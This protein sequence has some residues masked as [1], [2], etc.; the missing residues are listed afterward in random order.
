MKALVWTGV[1]TMEVRE[2][3]RPACGPDEILIRVEAV[4]ICG[5]EIEGY[6]GHNSL[7][8]PPLVMGHE[9]CGTVVDAGEGLPVAA[10]DANGAREGRSASAYGS[11]S[12]GQK[13]VVNPLLACGECPSCRRGLPQL[14]AKRALVGVHRPGAFGELVSVP[15]SAVVPVP[16]DISPFRA[17]LSEPLACSLRATRRALERHPFAGVLVFGAGGIGLLCAMTAKLLGASRVMIA[18]TNAK[19]L[20]MAASLD[21]G[22]TVNPRE[23]DLGERV[24]AAFGEGGLDAVM[25][26]AGFQPTREAA[27][28]L[29]RPGGTFMNIGLGIDDTVL[30]INH[31]IRGEIDIL[32]SFCYS[33]QD[34]HDAVRLLSEG[35]IT[36]EGWT[37]VRP[38]AAGG[39]AFA[40]LVAGR[41][42]VGKIFLQP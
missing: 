34:F 28:R 24:R 39:D 22:E 23:E 15:R 29:V 40:E 14:C 18:D 42:H 41:V 21:I 36:E 19:R 10:G 16:A 38:L 25:D 5:S 7:R 35:R 6:L 11:I 31:L 26:A 30:P 4:G 12:I 20:E 37:E 2:T 27:I 9:F 1:E 33:R 8:V 17:A 32:G 13:V 3:E